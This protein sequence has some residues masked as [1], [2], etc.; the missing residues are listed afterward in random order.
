MRI[1]KAHTLFIFVIVVVFLLG[2]YYYRSE[3]KHGLWYRFRLTPP[4]TLL[5]G[6]DAALA[7]HVGNYYFN[8]SQNDVYDLEKKQSDTLTGHLQLI[9]MCRAG[10]NSLLELIF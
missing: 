4:M 6:N 10:G 8:E 2:G 9:L 5:F 3:I 7:V 1:S